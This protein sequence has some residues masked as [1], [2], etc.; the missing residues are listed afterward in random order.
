MSRFRAR[1][2]SRNSITVR[3]SRSRRRL[4]AALRFE[5]LE[6]R[7]MLKVDLTLA[8]TQT[9]IGGVNI[10]ASA[11]PASANHD[12]ALAINPTNPL[13]VVGIS[14]KGAAYTSLGL[15]RSL[16]G[17]LTWATT[18]IDNSVDSLGAMAHRFDPSLAFDATGKLYVAYGADNG[19]NSVIVARSDDNDATFSQVTTVD[20]V[21]SIA[22][23]FSR[24]DVTTGPD[25]L[26][27]QAVYVAYRKLT[28]VSQGIE[29]AGSNDNGVTFSSP[30]TVNDPP[31]A[32]TN[33]NV[34]VGPHG[35]LYVSW[36]D[37][38]DQ[39]VRID[40][41]LDGLFVAANTFGADFT[42]V[43]QTM[44]RPT[45]S[46]NFDLFLNHMVPAQPDHGISTAPVLDVDH[47]G[48]STDGDLYIAFTDLFS[49]GDNNTDIYVA[50]S[51]NQGANW[52][53]VPVDTSSSTEFMPAIAVDQGSGS[54]SVM[55]Y[56]TNGDTAGN[57][58]VNV[59][60]S[61]SIDGGA[62]FTSP[63]TITTASSR[64][65]SA[66]SGG[67]DYFDYNGLAV[68]DG[69]IQAMWADYR[70]SISSVEAFT[71]S[72]SFSSSTDGNVLTV[73]GDDSGMPTDDAIIIRR[74]AANPAFVE[75]LVNG[76]LQY[77]GLLA[78]L[79]QINVNSLAGNDTLT[80][81]NSHGVV[82]VLVNYD[83]G[84][85]A[86]D[87]DTLAITGNPG[88]PIA[89]ETYVVGAMIGTGTWVLDPNGNRGA[90]LSV[91]GDG[92]E[93]TVNFVG[94]EP[95]DSDVPVAV[96][97]VL[98]NAADN[99][100]SI[101]N[102]GL[103]NG[104]NSF[105]V[106][107]NNGTFESFRFANKTAARIMGGLGADVFTVNYSIAAAGLTSLEIDGHFAADVMGQPPDDNLADTFS[108][109]TDAASV[110][111]T[112]AGNGGD[113]V[114]TVGNGDLTLIQSPVAVVGGDG[115]D[116]LTVDDSARMTDVD[117]HVDPTTIAI[118]VSPGPPPL[119]MN[120]ATFDATLEHAHL[121]G[122]QGINRFDVTPSASTEF[123]IDGNLPSTLPGDFLSI[124]FAGTTTP[125]LTNVGGTGQ[126][127][128]GNRMPVDFT[129][130]ERFNFFPVIVYGAD[131]AKNGKPTVKVVDAGSGTV[132]TSFQAYGANYTQGVRVAVGDVN[133]DGIP[134]IITAPGHN[135]S[136]LVKIFDLLSGT[137]I[138]TATLNAYSST[139]L[140][141]V[142]VAVGDVNGDGLNDL[143]VAPSRGKSLIRAFINQAATNPA[144]PFDSNH[145]NQF[146]AFPK[147]FIGGSTV[148]AGDVS[149][150]GRAEIVVGSGAGIRDTVRIFDGLTTA[151]T[152]TP[153]PPLQEFHPFE[154]NARGGVFVA[155][156]NI[157][158][159]PKLEI[160]VGSGVGGHSQLAT[161]DPA[162]LVAPVNTFL[163]VY[164]GSGSNAPVR[165]AAG[166]SFAGTTDI[167]TA[168][169]PDGKSQ[170]LRH[171][172]PAGPLVDF[173]MENDLEF[174]NGFFIAMDINAVAAFIC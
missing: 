172:P 66:A 120:I 61:T 141:G 134:E 164:S 21:A 137:A 64:I 51:T 8:G 146:L 86:M 124:R 99:N 103:L 7:R 34:S 15:Y 150:D 73:T 121:N 77:A 149:G 119:E 49:A 156:G 22:G 11:D 90:G 28:V 19:F 60:L 142:M 50:R 20:L 107:D 155:V 160:I 174:R 109:L 59:R 94:L 43:D 115:N 130:I 95:V 65:T 62:T 80:I 106:L 5:P 144:V 132:V 87:H 29:V 136:P 117:Y 114:F 78:T 129:H 74:S 116:S 91:A 41:D 45:L 67:N 83:G 44:A 76:A 168:Q 104:V 12:I 167:L 84:T 111:I 93:M 173:L 42:V 97:D 52:A 147:T 17:G 25:T 24:I 135:H 113:D 1:Q 148:A 159:D 46:G 81:D 118:C 54:A 105:Q 30:V 27:H 79:D 143:I 133:G 48:K 152:M 75:V 153:A 126:W 123:F 16:D 70:G 36:Y 158:V 92:D 18:T 53:I 47:S 2:V 110:P 58:D 35:E 89:R 101:L 166:S 122:T 108:V 13:D 100:A 32:V 57:D 139:Y 112:L 55:Y 6:D 154:A 165:V 162:S 40:R 102:G 96:F 68:V 127:T 163:A 9:L 88:T 145:V 38:T 56:S 171:T 125:H 170:M 140:G 82:N 128:F 33:P 14:Q 72:T 39:A 23:G 161:Y 26:G 71:A 63:Q 151:S 69:T 85:S 4:G 98:M 138:A 3:S 37:A 131:A 169:G 157:D 10:N 31:H